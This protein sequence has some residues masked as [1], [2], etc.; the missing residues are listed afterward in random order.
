MNTR[1]MFAKRTFFFFCRRMRTQYPNHRMCVRRVTLLSAWF[2]SQRLCV[3]YCC[4]YGLHAVV[5][6]ACHVVM[7]GKLS[8]ALKGYHID[9]ILDLRLANV[10]FKNPTPRRK[11][12]PSFTLVLELNDSHE[13]LYFIC[14]FSIKVN[15]HSQ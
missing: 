3:A 10:I 2:L 11:S 4:L 6:C 1:S 15:L 9:A 13:C 8:M 7:T 12:L 14:L 5:L